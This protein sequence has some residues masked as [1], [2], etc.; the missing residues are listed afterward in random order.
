MIVVRHSVR[1]GKDLG[2]GHNVVKSSRKLSR[3]EKSTLS[4]CGWQGKKGGGWVGGDR[5]IAVG[6]GAT[7]PTCLVVVI[8]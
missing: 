5:N 1:S 2:K 3:A 6:E 7:W 8:F 4:L